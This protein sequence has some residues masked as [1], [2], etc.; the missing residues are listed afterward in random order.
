MTDKGF[1]I[2]DECLLNNLKLIRPPFLRDQEQFEKEDAI[3]TAKI[4]SARVHVERTIQRIKIFQILKK[5]YPFNRLD[6]LDN[7][8]TIITGLVNL[9]S[10]ILADTRFVK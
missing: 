9:S 7:V 1:M 6:D 5:R 8:M 2:E 4:A 3:I 10:P